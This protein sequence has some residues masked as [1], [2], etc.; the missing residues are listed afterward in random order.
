[1]SVPRW[2]AAGLLVAALLVVPATPA[3]ADPAGPSDYRSSVIG[4]DPPVAG[5]EASI[6]GGDSF[7]RLVVDPATTVEVTGYR[8]EPY[9][10]FL[11]GGVVEENQ[12]APSTYL[13]QDRYAAV[14][15]PVTASADAT[16][17]WRQVADDGSYAWHDHR[18]HW[19]NRQP[20]PGGSPGDVVAEGVIPLQVDGVAV[21]L[22]I[23]SVWVAPPSR[24]PVVIGLLLG[25]LALPFMWR[26]IGWAALAVA[27]AGAA[28]LIVGLVAA[29]S[30]P[31]ETAPAW[32]LWLV[33]GLSLL[34]AAAARIGG[35]ID[36]RPER[37]RRMAASLILIGA[38]E[39]AM[40]T[41]LRRLW[42]WRA[43]LPTDA[44][45]WID[46]L[47]TAAALATAVTAT[48]AL[49]RVLAAPPGTPATR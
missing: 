30:V 2:T 43:V 8:G 45:F 17:E 10:R 48:M 29:R 15:V 23:R 37:S 49:V 4:L 6:I 44:P 32:W 31:A 5:V 12:R 14:Q 16:P 38:L 3:L 21:D 9:L 35:R 22:S 42:M 1:M 11:P 24:I 27:V 47:V 34:L 40:W 36:R 26:R 33:P 20:P 41:W 7:V 39:L 19:M 18:V 25:A 13:N 46:R 28:A